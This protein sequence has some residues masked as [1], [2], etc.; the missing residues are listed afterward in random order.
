MTLHPQIF[1][2]LAGLTASGVT[3]YLL[4]DPLSAPEELIAQIEQHGDPA[5]KVCGG[6]DKE[7]VNQYRE[8]FKTKLA[9]DEF[10]R[11]IIT[12]IDLFREDPA[13]ALAVI[14][15]MPPHHRLLAVRAIL[16]T[17]DDDGVRIAL[18][19]LRN[20]WVTA[21]S[22]PAMASRVMG[23]AASENPAAYMEWL[24]SFAASQAPETLLKMVAVPPSGFPEARGKCLEIYLN[25]LEKTG[26]PPGKEMDNLGSA[27]LAVSMNV[28]NSNPGLITALTKATKMPD[29]FH[30]TWIG[31]LQPGDAA[32]LLV[33]HRDAPFAESLAARAGNW[34]LLPGEQQAELT[35]HLSAGAVQHLDRGEALH[36]LVSGDGAHFADMA[37]KLT[38]DSATAA[39]SSAWLGQAIVLKSADPGA[40]LSALSGLE[41]SVRNR[42]TEEAIKSWAAADV[43]GASGF[44]ADHPELGDRA[45]ESLLGEIADDAESSLVWA[46]RL[47]DAAKRQTF[48][49]KFLP[50]LEAQDKNRAGEL[51]NL[52][53]AGVPK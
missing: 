8:L 36:G 30:K 21:A 28:L 33:Q 14:E 31:R 10:A 25:A 11:L 27:V 1:A 47:K 9:P 29:W 41:E 37:R 46:F 3:G 49:E 43:V 23:A 22:D 50:V 44:V 7:V 18:Y 20:G 19:A 4:R 32:E 15:G 6:P 42:V 51:M 45:V 35:I 16:Q 40:M 48:V 53:D 39:E 26:K 13:M 17:K 12:G 2:F 5:D 34:D 38:G 24:N 52:L